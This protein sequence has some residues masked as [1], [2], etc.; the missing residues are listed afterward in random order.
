MKSKR[1]QRTG[2]L[3]SKARKRR[4]K[5]QLAKKKA[6]I[7]PRCSRLIEGEQCEG[8]TQY[9][10]KALLRDEDGEDIVLYSLHDLPVCYECA[11][12]YGG[13]EKVP[14]EYTLNPAG[15]AQVVE[16]VVKNGMKRPSIQNS[17]IVL[18]E[19]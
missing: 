5:H 17:Q 4:K 11:K 13:D 14:I 2:I 18:G 10:L 6:G 16:F 1:K 9:F 3:S 8:K 19:I 15:W 7:S 12:H